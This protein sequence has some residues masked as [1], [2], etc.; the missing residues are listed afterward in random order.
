MYSIVG[1]PLWIRLFFSSSSR[2]GG[3][4]FRRYNSCTRFITK[5]KKHTRLP[6]PYSL[7]CLWSS[8]NRI[9]VLGIIAMAVF[10]YTT[11]DARAMWCSG[12]WRLSVGYRQCPDQNQ[13]KTT[14]TDSSANTFRMPDLPTLFDSEEDALAMG[15]EFREHIEN[16]VR[17]NR[18]CRTMAVSAP[19]P[20]Q[21]KN[22]R[23][24]ARLI[25]RRVPSRREQR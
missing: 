15:A 6:Y 13:S 14:I 22:A 25:H 24:A 20:P 4:R 7:I 18:P 10:Q 12:R 17:G 16:V 9:I 1:F 23:R 19:Q 11:N 21:F 2:G 5:K 3:A 8:I